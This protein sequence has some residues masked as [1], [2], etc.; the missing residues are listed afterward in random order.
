MAVAT[1]PSLAGCEVIEVD[2]VT[3]ADEVERRRLLVDS[4]FTGS[5]SIILGKRDEGG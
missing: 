4:G 1:F 2:F 5:S 3:L